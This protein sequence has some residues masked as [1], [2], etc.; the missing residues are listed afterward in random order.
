MTTSAT[1]SPAASPTAA[2]PSHAPFFNKA[3]GGDFFAPSKAAAAPTIQTKLAVSE[4]GDKLERE[5][6]AMAGK[7]MRM[8]APA[9][10][11]EEKLSRQ[12]DDKLKRAA[13]DKVQKVADDK[14]QRASDDK[15]QR[16]ADD[17]LRKAEMPAQKA[18]APEDKIAKSPVGEEKAQ[19]KYAEGASEVGAQTE[20]AIRNQS[21]PGQP[22]PGEERSF[23]ESRFG[24]DFSKVRIHN[25]QAAAS[26]CNQLHARAFTYQNHV[27]FARGQYQPGTVEGKKLLAHELS[28]TLQQGHALQRMTHLGEPERHDRIQMA[29]AAG[30]KPPAADLAAT[31]SEVV[32]LSSNAFAPSQKTKDEIEGQGN[33]GL[34]VRVV[35]KGLTGESRVKVKADS[36]KNHHSVGKGSMPLLNPWAD[37]LGGMYVNFTIKNGEIQGGY[38]SLK[39]GGGDTNEWLQALQKNAELLGGLGLKLGHLPTPVNKFEAGKLTLGV[40]NLKVEVGGFLDAVFN[41]SVEN[42]DKPKI[43]ATA[44]INVK[45]IAKGQ[46]HLDNSKDKLEGLI[47]LAIDYKSFSGSAIIKYNADGSV[48]I[49]GKG[50]YSADKLSGEVQFVSTDLEAANKFAK[51]AIAAAGGKENVQEAPPPGPVP[52]PK[53]NSKQR[54]LAATGQLAFNLTTWFAGTVCVV[55]DGKGM[56]TV[57]GKIAPPGEIELFKQK[58]WDKEIIKLEAKAYYGLPVVGNLNLF[59]NISLHAIAKLGPAKI[60][61][62][63]ILGTYST[64]PEIQKSIQISGSINISAYAGLKLRAEGGAGIEILSHDLKFG[65]GLEADV[66]VKAYADARPTVGYRDP[67]VFFISGTLDI[68]AQPMLGLGGDFFI[69]VET[70]WWSPLSDHRWTWPLFSKEWPMGDPIGISAVVKDYVLGSKSVP[71]IELKKPEFDPS[72][73]MTNMVDDKL[74][75][76]SGGK[77]AGQGSFKEDGSVPK[78]TVPPKKPAP[79]KG[80]AK[81]PGKKSAP[82]KGKSAAPDPK[83]AKEKDSGKILQQAAQ[84]LAALKGKGPM[85][86]S[87]LNQ[88]LGKIKAQV[89]DVDFSVQAKGD[90]WLVSPKAGGKSGKGIELP[91]KDAGKQDERTEAQKTHDLAAAIKE[92]TALV[93]DENK[94]GAEIQRALPEIKNRYKLTTIELAETPQ[95]EEEVLD[96]VK[97]TINPSASTPKKSHLKKHKSQYVTRKGGKYILKSGYDTKEHIRDS[98]YGKSYRPST[99]KWRDG[100]LAGKLAH[101]TD[102]KLYSWRGKWW[103]KTIL[104]ESP[105]VD[106]KTQ[107]V[108][109]HWNDEGRKTIQKTRADYFNDTSGCEVVPYG[110]NSSM[111]AKLAGSYGTRVTMS[112][113]GPGDPP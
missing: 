102:S 82:G 66:G 45:G 25:D 90:K 89:G 49:G 3:G 58:D 41:L 28:H 48:D 35:V 5:A 103:D 78:P 84:P 108:V 60:Y 67:G 63:E 20:S 55:V 101:P 37:K 29:P 40:S 77:G 107:P 54:A 61:N 52:A 7:V 87:E 85:R 19:R 46:L 39:P 6:D 33:K 109:D 44:D 91:A 111:G 96:A 18:A 105:T 53:A 92:A 70:P 13:D 97:A 23:M 10:G 32:E 75:E 12:P 112:F 30:A 24:A 80:D 69:A 100:L 104:R 74:P 95:G 31:S 27:F 4:P 88:E 62:I 59:A 17:K 98:F 56:V 72:K 57:I 51:D 22:L 8:P 71:E 36:A 81:P 76:K 21:S 113:R 79:K 1:K 110:E 93:E 50:A 64:D 34:D 26:L 42:G 9:P 68:V 2:H 14:V 106:H 11:Q 86:R 83:S 43:D 73:F 38:A 94:D 15:L 47:S 99:Y 16:Q 65:V